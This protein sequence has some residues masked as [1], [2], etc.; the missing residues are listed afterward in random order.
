[1]LEGELEIT[2]ALNA[3]CEEIL[4]FLRSARRLLVTASVVLSSPI[5]V[6]L[7]K[8]APSYSE[9]SVLTKATWH[10]IPEDTI[11]HSHCLEN[12]KSYTAVLTIT[13]MHVSCPPKSLFLQ[14]VATCSSETSFAFY[15]NNGV[16]SQNISSCVLCCL[17]VFHSYSIQSRPSP[18][19]NLY[20]GQPGQEHC[21]LA[22]NAAV[23]S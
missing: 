2:L 8:E 21:N 7:M 6:T 3:R 15:Q 23:A 17:S 14:R 5:L 12:P 20:F 9:T 11:L 22:V 4:V 16:I 19:C 1:M 18:G 10:N 13:F